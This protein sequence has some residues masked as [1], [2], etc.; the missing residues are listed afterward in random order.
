MLKVVIDVVA[1]D[2]EFPV[3]GKHHGLLVPVSL[4]T[5][6][7]LLKPS[8]KKL[9]R[10]GGGLTKAGLLLKYQ[11]PVKTYF[12]GDKRNPCFFELDTVRH[13]GTSTYGQF[14]RTLTDVYS[15]WTEKRA[16]RNSTHRWVKEQ[17]AAVHVALPFPLLGIDRDN[18]GEFIYHK[19]LAFGSEHLIRFTRSRPYRKNDN[20]FIEPKNG[21]VVRKNVSYQ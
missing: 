11:I 3:S 17:I 13:R 2:G 19:L 5:I 10:K 21:E 15:G 6:D 7:R 14:C 12:T 8:R 4:S 9:M 16:L 18:G 20:C 1:A